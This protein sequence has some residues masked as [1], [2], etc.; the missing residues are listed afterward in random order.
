MLVILSAAGISRSEV[1]AESKDPYS[2]LRFQEVEI[3]RFAQEENI[4]QAGN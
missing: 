4:V 3:L 2:R 1:P